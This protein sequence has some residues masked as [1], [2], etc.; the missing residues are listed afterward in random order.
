[1][2]SYREE[3]VKINGR[4][5]YFL[6]Y[7][8][9]V[10]APVFLFLHGGPGQSE[11]VMS[12]V[13]DEFKERTYTMVY[14][15][16]RTAGKTRLKNKKDV[17]EMEDLKEDLLE[18]VL[19][20]KKLYNKNKIVI[21]GH[22][23]GTVL[24]SLFAL[25]HPEHVL[26]YVGSGQLID[27]QE[28]EQVAYQRCKEAIVASKNEKDRKKLLSLGEYPGK[29]YSQD[30]YQKMGKMRRLQAKYGLGMKVDRKLISIVLHSPTVKLI[31]IIYFLMPNSFAQHL[32]EFLYTYSLR[33][34]GTNY[35]VPVY[36]ILG[37]QDQ[38]TPYQI[39]KTYFEEIIAPHKKLFLLEQ[40]GHLMMIDTIPAYRNALL[41]IS[42]ELHE[43]KV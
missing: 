9:E 8:G 41:E 5:H 4:E 15:D 11:S 35:Q 22:S 21:L 29:T 12:Y 13:A 39:A 14:Y 43:M 33:D 42:N 10:N 1:M 2:K 7:P 24:G 16:Q 17:P 36:Y 34:Y 31:D 26:A 40:S 30:A 6:H 38:Q 25:E 18:I 3:Y 27:M 19:Y 32:L 37:G 23:W 28:N 20:L